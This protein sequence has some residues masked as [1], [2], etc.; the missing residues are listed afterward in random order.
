MI[1]RVVRI[2]VA[3]F[4]LLS[5]LAAVGVGW[6]WR[7]YR[8]GRGYVAEGA[9]GGTYVMLTAEPSAVRIGV[10]VMR[11]WA[12]RGF[13]RVESSRE[14][15]RHAPLLHPVRIGRWERFHLFG[16]TIDGTLEVAPDTGEP[17][18]WLSSGVPREGVGQVYAVRSWSLL[19]VPHQGLIVA[20]LVPP[21]LWAGV[22]WRR[23]R[24]RSRRVRLGLC[25]ACGYDL[26]ESPE[27]CP[28]CGAV[29]VFAPP[30][31][32]AG[33]ARIR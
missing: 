19:G 28:E 3:T 7:E 15:E 26:R 16:Q 11:E 2:A 23:R 21:L 31:V 33:S 18:R 6:L 9:W 17:L 27:K 29:A 12:G 13:V 1:R 5:L 10:A 4:C 14:Y 8:H 25:L 24:E 20:G 30:A 32:R 22:R